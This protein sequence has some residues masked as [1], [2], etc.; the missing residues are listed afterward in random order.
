MSGHLLNAEDNHSAYVALNSYSKMKDP[1]KKNSSNIAAVDL[2]CGVGGLTRGLLNSGIEVVAGYD[3]DPA[4]RYAYEHNNKPAIF[5]EKS[6]SDITGADLASLYPKQAI[7]VL[8]GCA[9]CQPFSKYTQG[10][11]HS[12]DE[13]WGLLYQFARLIEEM[14]PEVITMENVPELKRHNVFLDFKALLQE[15][16]YAVSS[17]DV[18]CPDYGIPQ[19]RTRLV[20]FASLLGP[21]E[22]VPK[23]HSKK[24]YRT[25]RDAIGDLPTI[26]AG[27]VCRHDK[28]HRSVALNQM[29]M[30]RILSS[31]PGGTWRDWPE[32]LVAACH[33]EDSGKHY[34]S[35]YGRMK[36]DEPSPTITTQFY[37][38]GNGRFGHPDQARAISLREGAILQT[39][40]KSYNFVAPRSELS[41]KEVGRLIGNAV[42]VRLGKIV[43]DSIIKHVNK[44]G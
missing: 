39:F 28:L 36:W 26:E 18:F 16:G 43:G 33:Q 21:I 41:V 25:V 1:G 11:D 12:K 7:R 29:N 2:F 34:S 3:I 44:H 30:K 9:P 42:P 5:K 15:N 4:C 19:S 22:I 31:V 23:T 27:E 17:S 24:N 32:E 13:K 8:A 14:K 20:L 6:V 35:V 37:G 10:A 40:P 38:F